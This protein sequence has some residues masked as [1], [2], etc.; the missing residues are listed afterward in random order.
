MLRAEDRLDVAAQQLGVRVV[1]GAVERDDQH[2]VGDRGGHGGQYD[3]GGHGTHLGGRCG[4]ERTVGGSR[5]TGLAEIPARFASLEQ[6]RPG[7]GTY[8]LRR[9][10]RSRNAMWGFLPDGRGEWGTNQLD[11]S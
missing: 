7:T 6:R 1:Q 11:P 2:V 5:G 8:G 4:D 3:G 9:A 10:G